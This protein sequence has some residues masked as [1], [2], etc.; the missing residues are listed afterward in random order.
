MLIYLAS[1]P[2][3]GNRW[4]QV[5]MKHYFG[6]RVHSVYVAEAR[7]ALLTQFGDGL[8]K[9][10][11]VDDATFLIPI[12]RQ[13]V[14]AS[15]DIFIVKTHEPPFTQFFTGEKVIH[16]VRH[17]GAALWSYLHYLRDVDGVKADLEG[18]IQGNDGFGSWSVHTQQWLAAG[19]GLGQ[20]YLRYSY[21]Q[22]HQNEAAVAAN[23]ATFL[24]QPLLQPLGSLPGFEH[25]HQQ[26]PHLVRRG[27][28]D[29][30]QV[31]FTPAQHRLLLKVHGATMQ[32]LGYA[33]VMPSVTAAGA[34]DPTSAQ[35]VVPSAQSDAGQR[36]TRAV[37]SW[38]RVAVR[39][40][41]LRLRNLR[42]KGRKLV[43]R[44]SHRGT[45]ERSAPV[46][47]HI[48]QHKA[49]SQWVA[50]I[51]KHCVSPACVVLP[52]QAAAHFKPEH[53]RPGALF[54]TVYLP[55]N[56]VEAVTANFSG[57]IR[58]FV[59]IRDLR[60]TLVSLYFSLR[61]SHPTSTL[62]LQARTALLPLDLEEGMFTL[63]TKSLKIENDLF[64]RLTPG[65][66]ELAAQPAP[67]SQIECIARLQNSWIAAPDRLLIR[68]EELVADEQS[69]FKTIIDYCQIPI[70]PRR[71]H[72]LVADN[73]FSAMTGR[74]P[75][76]ED[77]MAHARKGI[78]GDWRNY[79]TD[80][81]KAEFKARYGEHLIYTGYEKDL[82]W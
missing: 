64:P 60:D 81:I 76:Q 47:L 58:R 6:L 19:G 35:P 25:Y 45:D 34:P 68:Y 72:Y 3:S 5:L 28:P 24:R 73:S 18:I 12:L 36:A 2:R 44:I 13:R 41:S 11:Y 48:T 78:V 80:A 66:A 75:G 55:R 30:W 40:A 8:P 61:Y 26:A 51:L 16:I 49:G 54:L 9:T 71:L 74:Q 77:I 63:L 56:K 43:A 32:A 1:Y 31:H 42:W 65:T 62:N 53:L 14:A 46:I 15:D 59:V 21:E 69:T 4:G 38:L 20:H 29:E 50:E 27:S 39:K 67:L 52:Q 22:L 82:H 70:A 17:P 57:P 33:T 7:H 23:L 79:F 37:R 10:A